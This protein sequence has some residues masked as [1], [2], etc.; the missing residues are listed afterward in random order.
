MTG[1]AEKYK[2]NERKYNRAAHKPIYTR[3]DMCRGTLVRDKHNACTKCAL[4]TFPEKAGRCKQS[5]IQSLNALR[6]RA[7]YIPSFF[8][9]CILVSVSLF[10]CLCALCFCCCCRCEPAA[11]AASNN[12]AWRLHSRRR[13]FGVL[14]V[15]VIVVVMAMVQD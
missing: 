2:I 12:G 8:L 7:G 1:I 10:V 14:R 15:V 11:P 4:R 13:T 3:G 9:C 5:E 6:C